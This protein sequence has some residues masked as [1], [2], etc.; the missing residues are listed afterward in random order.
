MRTKL[1]LTIDSKLVPKTKLYAKRKGKS[2]SQLVENMLRNLIDEDK[3]SFAKKWRG[4]L[5]VSHLEDERT[6]RLKNKYKL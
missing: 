4:S 6:K 5:K 2:V 1:N 3:T